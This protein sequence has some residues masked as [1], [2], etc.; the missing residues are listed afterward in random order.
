[1]PIV[2]A[3]DGL[4]SDETS[5][6]HSTFTRLWDSMDKK[7]EKRI[8]KN[9]QRE[10]WEC[11]VKRAKIAGESVRRFKMQFKQFDRVKPAILLPRLPELKHAMIK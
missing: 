9:V 3:S 2:L 8:D 7:I 6:D 4:L 1:M 10:I 5:Q 11:R